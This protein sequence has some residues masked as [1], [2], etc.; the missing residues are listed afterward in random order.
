MTKEEIQLIAANQKQAAELTSELESRLKEAKQALA[1]EEQI[2]EAADKLIDSGVVASNLKDQ[3]VNTLSSHKEALDF[4]TQIAEDR[5][6]IASAYYEVAE[7][8]PGT[9]VVHKKEA[10][11]GESLDEWWSTS[12]NR[13]RAN[14]SR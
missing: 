1:S 10:S 2:K 7:L 4:M 11:Q 5:Q 12:I 14:M 9:S 3:L 6:K 8:N 13:L